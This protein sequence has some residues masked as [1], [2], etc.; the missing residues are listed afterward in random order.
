MKARVHRTAG[1]LALLVATGQ[2]AL[3]GVGSRET[4]TDSWF[5]LGPWMDERGVSVGASYLAD[6]TTVLAGGVESSHAYRHR[7]DVN[8]D[9]A[10]ESLVGWTGANLFVDFQVHKGQDGSEYVGDLQAFSNLD[11]DETTEVPE[12]WFQ[13]ELGPLRAKLGKVD[14]NSGS[15]RWTPRASSSTRPP[16]SAQPC[17]SSRP[18]PTRHSP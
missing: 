9:V 6:E 16:A 18:I 7:F 13:Q 11:A 10:L 17:S 14:G 2:V 1:A 12:A 8:V 3:A 15:V 4:V 5:G